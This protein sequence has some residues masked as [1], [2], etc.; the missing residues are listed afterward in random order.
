MTAGQL[1]Q[2]LK[3][4]QGDGLA[5]I[6]GPDPESVEDGILTYTDAESSSA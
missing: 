5:V 2:T 1:I 3:Q 4:V 6:P